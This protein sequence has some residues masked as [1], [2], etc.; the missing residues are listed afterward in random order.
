MLPV[1]M[2]INTSGSFP[3]PEVP[4]AGRSGWRVA[5]SN[6]R[7]RFGSTEVVQP[8]CAGLD[9]SKRDDKVCVRIQGRGSRPTRATVTTWGSTTRQI[10][11]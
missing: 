1:S 7:G 4:S 11:P 8:R 2:R 5:F 6:V 9:V 10:S 3:L